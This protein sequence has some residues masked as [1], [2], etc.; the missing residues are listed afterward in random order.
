MAIVVSNQAGIERGYFNE[1]AVK[2][3]YAHVQNELKAMGPSIDAFYFCPHHPDEG[4]GEYKTICECRKSAPGMLLQ[5]A[6]EYRCQ[7][8]EFFYGW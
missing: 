3:L 7:P 1:D 5:A 2:T 8:E 4:I 6:V